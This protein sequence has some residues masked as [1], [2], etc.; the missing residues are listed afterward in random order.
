[1]Q[2]LK[3]R[4]LLERHV[5]HVRPHRRLQL[6]GTER[7]EGKWRFS[8]FFAAAQTTDSLFA[9]RKTL[10]IVARFILLFKSDTISHNSN[11]FLI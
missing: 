11:L 2:C 7:I 9:D 6:R 5:R 10:R 8:S 4:I 3:F 1:M